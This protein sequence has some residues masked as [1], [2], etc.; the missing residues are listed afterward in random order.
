M[1]IDTIFEC[2]YEFHQQNEGTLKN[3]NGCTVMDICESTGYARTAVSEDLSRLTARHQVI[4][5]KSRP[6]LFFARSVLEKSFFFS[7]QKDEYASINE[8]ESE[9]RH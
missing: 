3:L 8:L 1:R 7:P 6:V 4:K 2:L 5:V 9:I